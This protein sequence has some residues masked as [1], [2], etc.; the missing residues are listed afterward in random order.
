MSSAMNE[1]QA[2]A[3]IERRLARDDPELAQRIN[4]INSQFTD[5]AGERVTAQ[6]DERLTDHS[7]DDRAT[8]KAVEEDPADRPEDG[9][10]SRSWTTVIVVVFVAVAVLGMLLTAVLSSPGG[11]QEPLQ[12]NGLAPPAISDVLE[13]RP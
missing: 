13:G 11:K 3:R 9:G 7:T 2:F 4:A 5:L 10:D 12:P 6:V 8:D 1:R